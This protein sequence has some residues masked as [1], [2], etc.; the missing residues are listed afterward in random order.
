MILYHF[1]ALQ[2]LDQIKVEGLSKGE[3]PLTANRTINAVWFTTDSNSEG[4]G[5]SDSGP[6][7]KEWIQTLKAKGLLSADAP[8]E[9]LRFIDK[10]AVRIKVVIPSTD[11]DLKRWVPWGRKHLERQWFD[12]LSDTGGGNQ[13]A[14]SWYLCFRTITPAEF[15]AI[16]ILRPDS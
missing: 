2:L 13:K 1:T 9:G 3:V 16:D 8:N 4:H 5:L 6:I 7:P 15:T 11:R 14:R 12:T 10:R